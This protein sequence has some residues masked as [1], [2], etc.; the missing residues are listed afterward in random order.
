MSLLKYL[1]VPQFFLFSQQ[2]FLKFQSFA[3][4]SKPHERLQGMLLIRQSKTECKFL[5]NSSKPQPIQKQL[6]HLAAAGWVLPKGCV[7]QSPRDHLF[8]FVLFVVLKKR[9]FRKFAFCFVVSGVLS[10]QKAFCFTFCVQKKKKKKKSERQ[11]T[12]F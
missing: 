12:L 5:R 9:V 2:N 10:D 1:C 6:N 8:L 7:H 4:H 3:H 11:S